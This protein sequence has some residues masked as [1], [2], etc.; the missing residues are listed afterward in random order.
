V[1]NVNKG[2]TQIGV[3]NHYYWYRLKDEKGANG[4]HSALQHF[5]PHDDGY[6]LDVSGAGVLKSSQHQQAA[7]QLVAFLVAKQGQQVLASGDSWE[8]P[9][10]SGVTSPKLS[11]LSSIQAKAFDLTQIGDGSKAVMLLQQAGLL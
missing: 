7:Q 1:D 3:I 4:I 8:Y 5:A 6:L 11:P 10:G 9:I 2:T